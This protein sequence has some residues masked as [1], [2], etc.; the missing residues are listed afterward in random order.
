MRAVLHIPHNAVWCDTA[1]NLLIWR[2]FP[3]NVYR[4]HTETLMA[5][6]VGRH[7]VTIPSA[8]NFLM[9]LPFTAT[10]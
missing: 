2:Y 7:Y 6:T 10:T 9:E 4:T 8:A 1:F 5:N 3:C